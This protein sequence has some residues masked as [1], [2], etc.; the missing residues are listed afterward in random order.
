VTD[1]RVTSSLRIGGVVVH[2]DREAGEGAARHLVEQL[3]DAGTVGG[4]SGRE[5]RLMKSELIVSARSSIF[6]F[7]VNC[8][9]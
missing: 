9:V 3:R 6:P 8:L 7:A 5:A 4:G 1:F 2:G